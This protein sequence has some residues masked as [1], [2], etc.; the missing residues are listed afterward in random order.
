[1]TI[2]DPAVRPALSVSTKK[3]QSQLD[4]YGIWDTWVGILGAHIRGSAHQASYILESEEFSHAPHFDDDDLQ[5]LSVGQIS[6]LYEFSL[7]YTSAD[8]RKNSGQYFTPDDVAQMMAGQASKFGDG[9]WL[10]PCAGVGNLSYWLVQEQPNPLDFLRTRLLVSDKDPLALLVARTLL[11]LAFP[12]EQGLFGEI[13]KNFHVRDFL[14]DEVIDHD[15]ILMNPP[16]VTMKAKD[17]RFETADSM[18]LF[19]WFMERAV[20]TSRGFISITPQGFT[21]GDKFQSLRDLMVSTGKGFDIMCFD[22]MPDTI[23]RG[24]K[25]GSTNTNQ[26]N[27]TR[28]AVTVF[29][30][31]PEKRITRMLRW[32]ATE[33]PQM[34]SC[35]SNFLEPMVESS[36]FPKAS[37]GTRGLLEQCS[38]QPVL[39][40]YL[41]KKETPY[42]LTVAATPRYY[43]SAV[44]RPLQRSSSRMLYFATEEDMNRVYPYLNSSFLFWWW[45]V[46]DGELT[47]SQKTLWS[48]PLLPCV[49]RPGSADFIQ[50][51]ERSE[52]EN[53]M[54][55]MNA[56][57]PN[58]NVKHPEALIRELNQHYFPEWVDGLMLFHDNSVVKA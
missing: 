48:L 54:V 40:D 50:T 32:T 37:E 6:A 47:I 17:D 43:T 46:D 1:M 49:D 44:R 10:D 41:V 52:S 22:N 24:I 56:G 58:E 31:T 4:E 35:A 57:R 2:I 13:E 8:S 45:M 55:K 34:L 29:G 26:K 51:L 53:L 30:A 20:K 25:F 11:S 27:S 5:G 14:T 16:Y 23:F 21:N 33:R 3:L 38:G 19:A 18:N 39:G 7:S 15:F 36:I 12:D 9:V 28:A 42:S